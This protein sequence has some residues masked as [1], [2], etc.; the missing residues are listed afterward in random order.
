MLEMPLHSREVNSSRSGL[1]G[2]LCLVSCASGPAQ[3][4]LVGDPDVA[5]RVD[6]SLEQARKVGIGANSSW[7]GRNARWSW[8]SRV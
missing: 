1:L 6:H 5:E 3:P 2:A 8:R 7:L 4:A